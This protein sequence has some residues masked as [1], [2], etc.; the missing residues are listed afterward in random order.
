MSVLNAIRKQEN[1]DGVEGHEERLLMQA[2]SKYNPPKRVFTRGRDSH[3]Y[4]ESDIKKPYSDK[5]LLLQAKWYCQT[6]C[7][8]STCPLKGV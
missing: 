4:T 3:K 6:L 2:E 1:P 5:I 7:C 8:D